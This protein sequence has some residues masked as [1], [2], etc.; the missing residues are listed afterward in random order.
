MLVVKIN[1][2][3]VRWPT[4]TLTATLGGQNQTAQV[5]DMRNHFVFSGL[6]P[7]QRR[8]TVHFAGTRGAGNAAAHADV[9]SDQ[10]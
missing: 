4:G 2:P 10:G 1:A 7:G 3:S 6:K 5:T 9:A 8:L